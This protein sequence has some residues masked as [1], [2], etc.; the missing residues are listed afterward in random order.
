MTRSD[1]S[2]ILHPS[3]FVEGVDHFNATEFWEAHESWEQLWLEADG[4][5]VEF[6][7]GLI[8]LAAAYHHS[9]RGT[10]RGAVRLFDASLRRLEP[11]P[12]QFH[13]LDRDAATTAARR[14]REW[15]AANI[16]S[17]A[18]LDPEEFPK[19]ILSRPGGA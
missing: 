18:R 12:R 8:Q 9:K 11:F 4:D 7:Q 10:L 14:H 15:A 16:E 1:S 17:G 5:L 13:D 3:A 6:Y 19:L 2:F